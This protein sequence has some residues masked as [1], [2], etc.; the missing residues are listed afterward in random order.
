MRHGVR[1]RP[2]RQGVL[3]GTMLVGDQELYDAL[4]GKK[5]VLIGNGLTTADFTDDRRLRYPTG[6][7]GVITGMA[8]TSWRP[9][10][11]A[12]ER[13]DH[14]RQQPVGQAAYGCC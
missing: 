13:G 7:V 12:E 11:E 8:S 2:E 6:S 5:P 4:N 10:P 14:V 1:Q 9:Q 3:T